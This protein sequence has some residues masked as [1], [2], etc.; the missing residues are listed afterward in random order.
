MAQ[1][2]FGLLSTEDI[3][4]LKANMTKDGVIDEATQNKLIAKLQNGETLDCMDPVKTAEASK[5]LIATKDNPRAEYILKMAHT[6]LL[7]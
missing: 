7:K 5:N 2:W 6:F 4:Q 3:S 1:T